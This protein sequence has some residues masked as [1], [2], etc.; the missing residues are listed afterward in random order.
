[1]K[2]KVHPGLCEGHGLCHRWAPE[3]YTLDD[4][5]YIDMHL[6]EVPPELEAAAEIGASVCPAGVITI[7]REPVEVFL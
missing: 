4:E 7:I 3:V 6:V 2:I 1:M 5:G